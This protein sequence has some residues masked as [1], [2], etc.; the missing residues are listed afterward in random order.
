MR[1]NEKRGMNFDA[2]TNALIEENAKLRAEN[3]KLKQQRELRCSY[4]S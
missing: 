3:E 4:C 2:K 1:I